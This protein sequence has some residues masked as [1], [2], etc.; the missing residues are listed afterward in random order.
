VSLKQI[1]VDVLILIAR[2]REA[3]NGRFIGVEGAIDEGGG[4]VP[5]VAL[6][7]R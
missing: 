1:G 3:I 5:M 4:D 7:A 6:E 2:W